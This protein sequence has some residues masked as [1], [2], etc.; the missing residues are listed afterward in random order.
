MRVLVCGGRAFD[1]REKLFQSLDRQHA[2]TP[3]SLL[4]E[5]GARGADQLAMSWAHERGIEH[6]RFD[7]DWEARGRAA[8]PIRNQRML[9]EGRP[10]VV[11]AFP[12]GPRH[13]GYDRA[14]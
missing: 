7:A 6:L 5:G 13:S 4:I 8:G 3:F 12:G 11:I 1:D 2:V 10:D 9:D 14:R